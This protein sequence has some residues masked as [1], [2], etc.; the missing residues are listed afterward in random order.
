MRDNNSRQRS[1]C[2]R[3]C[4]YQK[5]YSFYSGIKQSPYENL[6]GRKA[7]LGQQVVLFRLLQE[8]NYFP[9]RCYEDHKKYS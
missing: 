1:E 2:T 5:N 8:K 3:F 4:E 9:R 6:F 7:D